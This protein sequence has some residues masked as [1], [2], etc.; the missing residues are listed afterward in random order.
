MK[1][2]SSSAGINSTWLSNG[3]VERDLGVLAGN[4]L[5]RS[6]QCDTVAKTSNRMVGC[7]NKGISTERK[8]SLSH[9]AQCRLEKTWS[10]VCSFGPHCR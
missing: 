6:E 4:K 9:S 5:S 1:P 10:T 2:R 3:P 7:S 8:K